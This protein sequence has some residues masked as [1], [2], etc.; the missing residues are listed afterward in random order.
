M[1]TTATDAYAV[2]GVRADASQEEIEAMYKAQLQLLHPDRMAGRPGR[3]RATARHMLDNLQTAWSL[4]GDERARARYDA[5]RATSGTP[6]PEPASEPQ[7]VPEWVAVDEPAS[8]WGPVA[9]Q[10]V[11]YTPPPVQ[12]A[13]AAQTTNPVPQSYKAV[14]RTAKWEK[15][16][17][18]VAVAQARRLAMF[19]CHGT[20]IEARPYTLGLVIGANEA[21]WAE[22]WAR[23]SLDRPPASSDPSQLPLSCWL[24]TDQRLVGRLSTGALIGWR[25][26][27]IYAY[28]ADLEPGKEWAH[29]DLKDCSPV[30]WY[31]PGVAPLAV[32]LVAQVHGVTAL[33]EHPGLT[34]LQDGMRRRR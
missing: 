28:R 17:R 26:D 4:V 29:I 12:Q 10:P 22:T 34:A 6:E 13:T 25:W 21:V 15:R 19:F 27:Q 18:A 11:R 1:M 7:P 5:E 2:L 3:E 23:C 8:E 14:R 32:V 16:N 30:V 9:P 33:L 20:A 31:G 24:A